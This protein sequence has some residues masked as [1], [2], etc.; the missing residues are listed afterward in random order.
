MRESHPHRGDHGVLSELGMYYRLPTEESIEA[1]R[2]RAQEEMALYTRQDAHVVSPRRKKAREEAASAQKKQAREMQKRAKG[3]HGGDVAVG[4]VVQVAVDDVDRAKTDDTNATLVVVEVV[5]TGTTEVE[6][7]Y[8]LACAAGVI[9]TVYVR[10]YIDPLP[11]VSPEVMG[12]ATA[13]ENWQGM[14]RVGLREA[15]RVVSAVGGQG[16]VHCSCMGECQNN[17]CACFKAK[18]KCN[19]RCHKGNKRCCNHD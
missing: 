8:R 15:M 19:S 10:S 14:P 16:L 12:L 4:T 18:R 13:L 5:R 9:K 17:R 2:V 1:G 7:K 3:K 6:D 11:G